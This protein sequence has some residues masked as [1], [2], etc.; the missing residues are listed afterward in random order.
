VVH[1]LGASGLACGACGA[2][3]RQHI[4]AAA[5]AFLCRTCSALNVFAAPR[6]APPVEVHLHAQEHTALGPLHYITLTPTA[7]VSGGPNAVADASQCV[8]F[9]VYNASRKLVVGTREEYAAA[10]AAP[11]GRQGSSVDMGVSG[12]KE[13]RPF[14]AAGGA[15]HAGGGCAQ[16]AA[17]PLDA[18]P[19]CV[20]LGDGGGARVFAQRGGKWEP[21]LD[22]TP[23]A[24]LPAL[25]AQAAAKR[26]L[27]L[28]AGVG[29]PG[30]GAAAG[31]AAAMAARARSAGV[32]AAVTG[33]VMSAPLRWEGVVNGSSG[34][35]SAVR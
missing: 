28:A 31:A 26:G 21:L 22:W 9:P 32:A 3:A 2:A 8:S 14:A 18:A 7:A 24:A 1:R 11:A 15:T 25:C 13:G 5:P 4:S 27:A 34:P 35:G 33:G 10:A 29:A 23:Q 30:A 12:G 6:H 16:V 17:L 19:L 20:R